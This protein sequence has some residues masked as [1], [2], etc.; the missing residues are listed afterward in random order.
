[1]SALEISEIILSIS[2]QHMKNER[3][4]E[5]NIRFYPQGHV[6]SCCNWRGYFS[7]SKANTKLFLLRLAS[8]WRSVFDLKKQTREYYLNINGRQKIELNFVTALN[9][10]IAK[11]QN[12][13][14]STAS[15]TPKK[16]TRFQQ[17]LQKSC[18]YFLC[19]ETYII[20][21]QKKP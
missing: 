5:R 16:L 20:A 6:V 7:I 19:H 3:T 1:M 11:S 12:K 13:L 17:W 18:N 4:W 9:Q 2:S 14:A 15:Q 8:P 21:L 10:T